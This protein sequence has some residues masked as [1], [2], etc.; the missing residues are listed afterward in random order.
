MKEAHMKKSRRFYPAIFSILILF[1]VTGSLYAENIFVGDDSESQGQ[2]NTEWV[3][4]EVVSV[5]A[6]NNTLIVKYFDYEKEQEKQVTFYS[7]NKTEFENI[8]SL[9]DLKPT[10]SV[11]IDYFVAEGGKNFIQEISLD[12]P[13]SESDSDTEEEEINPKDLIQEMR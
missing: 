4:G 3:W 13:D 12:K 2:D 1:F 10:D 6:V 5:D 9:G 7:Y 8:T 11:S